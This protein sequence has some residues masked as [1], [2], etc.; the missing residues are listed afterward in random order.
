MQRLLSL[1]AA[2]LVSPAFA[3]AGSAAAQSPPASQIDWCRLP[4]GPN[5]TPRDV[6]DWRLHCAVQKLDAERAAAEDRAMEAEVEAASA[7][8]GETAAQTEL[9]ALKKQP[10]APA[11]LRPKK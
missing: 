6:M 5:A 1:V 7:K 10:A 9:D 3:G 4:L 11:V 2:L 8:A